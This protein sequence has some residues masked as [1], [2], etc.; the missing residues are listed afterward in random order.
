MSFALGAV[1]Q[2]QEC[3]QIMFPERLRSPGETPR[4]A[5]TERPNDVNSVV[6]GKT[7]VK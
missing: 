3:L 4:S 6:S 7:Q 1:R 2:A 5:D